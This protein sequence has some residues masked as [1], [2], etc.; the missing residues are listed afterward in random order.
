MVCLL[1]AKS[2]NEK[3]EF[4]KSDDY[5]SVLISHQLNSFLSILHKSFVLGFDDFN[6]M[7]PAGIYEYIVARTRFID[8]L[9]ATLPPETTHVFIL[10]AGY[11]SRAFRF[12]AQLKHCLV[13]ECDH[14]DMQASKRHLL[15]KSDIDYPPNAS[16]VPLDF[17]DGSFAKWIQH[18]DLSSK[19]R[20]FFLLEGLL[21]YLAPPQV[22]HIFNA[23]GQLKA[24]QCRV[25][26]DYAYAALTREE[27]GGYHEA[28][29]IAEVKTV[30]EPWKFGIEQGALAEFLQTYRLTVLEE[31]TSREI[32]RSKFTDEN[33]KCHGAV[34]DSMA[35]VLAEGIK[36]T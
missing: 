31:L 8:D 36:R 16:F 24:G 20:C 7:L 4:Y 9:F 11:D 2:F 18:L 1:R 17:S 33:G 27:S 22:D 29:C 28:Q 5:I 25:F 19:D 12:Q 30:G 23:I 32:E 3:R 35:W 13:Y 14:P 21:M 10:G 26:F 6:P 34:M 15:E